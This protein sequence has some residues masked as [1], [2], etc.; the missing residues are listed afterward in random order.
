MRRVLL[1]SMTV[2]VLA[3]FLLGCVRTTTVVKE[4]LDQ[5]TEGNRGFVCGDIPAEVEDIE[6]SRTRTITQ[7]EI[8]LPFYEGG[9]RYRQEDKEVWGNEGVVTQPKRKYSK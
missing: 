1:L 4:R 9:E 8:E 5:V 2:L 7:V 3:I 6:A